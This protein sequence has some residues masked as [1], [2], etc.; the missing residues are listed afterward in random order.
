MMCSDKLDVLVSLVNEIREVQDLDGSIKDE[1][2]R[3]RTL[4]SRLMNAIDQWRLELGGRH[5]VILK[6]I[7]ADL[8]SWMASGIEHKPRFDTAL[9]GFRVPKDGESVIFIA[10]MRA[11]NGPLPDGCKLELINGTRCETSFLAGA[12]KY[13]N[14]YVAPFQCIKLGKASHGFSSGNCIVLFPES[15][16][17][18]RRI[19]KQNFALFFFSKF[20]EIY[21]N[22][23]L[24]EVDRLFGGDANLIFGGA[25]S[26]GMSEESVYD[27]R[28]LWG[29]YHDYAHHSGPRPLN[30][31]L[32]IKMNWYAG[33]LEEVKCDLKVVSLVVKHK[34][35]FWRQIV[36][37]V[38]FERLFRYP[39]GSR[40]NLTFDAGTGV[41][42]FEILFEE[43]A[44][45]RRRDGFLSFDEGKLFSV[46]SSVVD[47]IERLEFLNDEDYIR[48]ARS[49]VWSI[50]GHPL[51]SGERFDLLRTAYAREVWEG[52]GA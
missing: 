42:L 14:G 4:V 22:Q 44:L 30:N 26:R 17:T 9:S 31:N 21:N 35:D 41:L 13:T 6:S 2:F 24:P 15:V 25:Q 27:A 23:T 8:R 49:Y 37:F 51:A 19:D 50:L 47:R 5:D 28:C 39:M 20:Y 33:L 40:S 52:Q 36:E 38:L 18:S 7:L 45:V 29:Y 32:Y 12:S 46:I 1:V 3:G 48:E 34:P 43:R 16:S 10:P 11:T